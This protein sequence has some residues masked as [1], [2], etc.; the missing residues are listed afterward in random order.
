MRETRVRVALA[1]SHVI[2]RCSKRSRTDDRSVR[3]APHARERAAAASARGETATTHAH[4]KQPRQLGDSVA[5]FTWRK[6]RTIFTQNR[7][8]F[9]E[10][11]SSVLFL[12]VGK[13]GALAPLAPH[14]PHIRGEA[15][16]LP[17]VDVANM[18]RPT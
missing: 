6:G 1:S 17:R 7:H 10:K 5:L 12:M 2:E 4:A 14:I 11:I 9:D 8:I 3:A 18:K 16:I 15:L 13:D